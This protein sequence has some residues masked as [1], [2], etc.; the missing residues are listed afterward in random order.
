MVTYKNLFADK[1]IRSSTIGTSL[2]F[3]MTILV[4][5]LNYTHFPP[6]LPLY[7]KLAWGYARLGHTYEIAIPICLALFLCIGNILF[8]KYI[9]DRVPL[10]ARFLSLTMLLIGLFICIFIIKLTLI[11]L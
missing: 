8:A 10:L 3:L 1:I 6:F 7:N 11:I 9:Y 4:V 2:M 5:L